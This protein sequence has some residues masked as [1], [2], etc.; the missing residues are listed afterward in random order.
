LLVSL[1][2]RHLQHLS[3]VPDNGP[4]RRFESRQSVLCF[5]NLSLCWLHTH[6]DNGNLRGMNC[7]LGMETKSFN[8]CRFIGQT[9]FIGYVDKGNIHTVNFCSGAGHHQLTARGQQRFPIHF[10]AKLAGKITS[11]KH[12]RS[13]PVG[14]RNF[15]CVAQPAYG[16]DERNKAACTNAQSRFRDFNFHGMFNHGNKQKAWFFVRGP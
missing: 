5:C 2:N 4:A 16:F 15:D 11:A 13:D 10:Y 14:S 12:H 9:S 6:F 3:L 7:R 1:D 8:T